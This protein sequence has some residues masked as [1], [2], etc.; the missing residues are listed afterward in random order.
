MSWRPGSGVYEDTPIIQT[1][2]KRP[3]AKDG[4]RIFVRERGSTAWQ[5]IQWSQLNFVVHVEW[6]QQRVTEAAKAKSRQSWRAAQ[7]RRKATSDP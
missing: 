7:E 1:A 4:P 2:Q 6:R 3:T 5:S